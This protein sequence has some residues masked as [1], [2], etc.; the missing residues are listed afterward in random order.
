M[1]LTNR[2]IQRF[3]ER[4]PIEIQEIFLGVRD[5]IFAAVPEAWERP[6]MGGL[7]YYLTEDSTPLKGMICHLV[8]K[9]DEVEIGF[10]FGAFLPDPCGWLVGSQKAKR[11]LHLTDYDAV[12]W[13]YLVGLM[14]ASAE[15]DPS[16]FF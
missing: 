1:R 13:D 6:K 5:C 7:A 15:M 16:K 2:E 4:Y 9:S 3:L 10:I 8:P 12:D 11:R 14:R